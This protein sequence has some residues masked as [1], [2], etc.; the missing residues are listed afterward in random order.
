[1]PYFELE[2]RQ[3]HLPDRVHFLVISFVT[4]I[5]VAPGPMRCLLQGFACSL[6]KPLWLATVHQG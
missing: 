3:W 2:K 4:D 5:P 1:M 6:A